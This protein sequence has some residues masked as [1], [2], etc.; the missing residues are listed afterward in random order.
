MSSAIIVFREV[1]EAALIIGIVMAAT[2]GVAARSLWVGAGIG[3][4]LVG[5]TLVALFAGAIANAAEGMGQ[6][7]FNA[8][9]LF[10]AVIMLGWHNVWMS[11]H[12]RELSLHM[13]DVGASVAGG[14]LPMRA[15]TAV[16]GLAV[17]REGSETVL[18]LY[19]IAAT[20]HGPGQMVVGS[21]V[22][23][24]GGLIAGAAL[25]FGLLRIPTRHLFKVTSWMILFLAAGMASEGA[26][27]LVQADYLPALGERLWD[28]SFLLSDRS[29]LGQAL[30]ILIGYTPRP[31]GIQLVFYGLTI[32]TIGGLMT[33]GS[34]V[35]LKAAAAVGPVVGLALIFANMLLP[36]PASAG[37]TVYSPIVHGG[38]IEFET[39][40]KYEIDGDPASDGALK[41]IYEVGYAF[42]DR[43]KS[44][45]FIKFEK[46]PGG[47]LKQEAVAW[48]NII[49]LTE[50]GEY[51]ADVG[52]YLEYESSVHS[53]GHNKVEAKLLLEKETG[54]FVHTANIIFEKQVSG[55]NKDNLELEYAL[56][57]KYRHRKELEFGIEAFGGFGEIEDFKPRS[58]QKHY[59]GP[60]LS[61]KIAIKPKW[62]VK[63]EAGYLFG[64]SD[65]A[66]DGKFK[67][68]IELETYF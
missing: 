29:Y 55:Q 52:L 39:K 59:L 31:M 60:V 35:T 9:V 6:E 45:I 4:G 61:G 53:A 63:Y 14:G 22:G 19:G 27:F 21:L 25:Y 18:F 32:L 34:K 7:L 1:L 62:K 28:T 5:A 43:W 20:A 2:R 50:Q 8:G 47:Q 26:R 10:A 64:I 38:E 58:E 11:Q 54:D 37:E 44:A 23:L 49:Q 42:T 15:L 13:T 17:L 12:A 24:L 67:W 30:H 51:W 57:S 65:A 40:G 41:E 48:E 33:L 56:R 46:A 36:R 16:V 3:L 68:M 66:S